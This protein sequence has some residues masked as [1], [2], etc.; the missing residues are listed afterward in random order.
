M[1]KLLPTAIPSCIIQHHHRLKL[2]YN[3]CW[4]NNSDNTKIRKTFLSR[5]RPSL[6]HKQK[7]SSGYISIIWVAAM[8]PT[9]YE[10]LTHPDSM[11]HLLTCSCYHK[12]PDTVRPSGYLKSPSNHHLAVYIYIHM[13]P[14]AKVTREIELASSAQV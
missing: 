1:A 4:K 6:T 12:E 9:M 3:I 5:L 8:H 10:M 14:K 11:I 13:N 2:V 7:V